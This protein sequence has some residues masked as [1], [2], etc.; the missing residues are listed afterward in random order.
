MSHRRTLKMVEKVGENFNEDIMAWKRNKEYS[1]KFELHVSSMQGEIASMKQQQE[2]NIAA[3][4]TEDSSQCDI[5]LSLTCATSPDSQRPS[6]EINIGDLKK[7]VICKLR[8]KFD[9]KVFEES[10]PLLN[11]TAHAYVLPGYQIIGDNVDF[12]VKAKHMSFTK[13]NDSVHWFNLNAILDG[14]T[15]QEYSSE[16]PIKSISN[17]E[18]IDFLPSAR[19]NQDL[20]RDLI[21]LVSR[22]VVNRIPAF[23]TFKKAVV[24]NIP[25]AYSEV[26]EKQSEQVRY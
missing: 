1:C 4:V 18:N 20:L 8:R 11:D 24:W 26:M 10:L 3:V 19:E 23:Q 17:V 7:R 21:P 22:V 2:T 16:K 14:V 13:Q 15:G 5:G 12:L 25:H 6:E 9:E